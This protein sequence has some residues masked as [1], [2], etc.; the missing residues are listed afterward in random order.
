MINQ[1]DMDRFNALG[2]LDKEAIIRLYGRRPDEPVSIA[3]DNAFVQ[4]YDIGYEEGYDIGYE[5]GCSDTLA[6]D[7]EENDDAEP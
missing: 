6:E 1:I 7:D 5:E 3:E 4:G 2:S